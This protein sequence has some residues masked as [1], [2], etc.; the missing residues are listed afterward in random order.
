MGVAVGAHASDFLMVDERGADMEVSRTRRWRAFATCI[1][2]FLA[3][4]GLIAAVVHF[5][6]PFV[7]EIAG[8]AGASPFWWQVDQNIVLVGTADLIAAVLPVWLVCIVTR[9][10][11]ADLGYNRRGTWLAWLVVLTAQA[12]LLYLDTK[13]GA[14]GHARDALSPYALFASAFVGPAAAFSEET[15][16]RG[17]MTEELRRGGFGI[18][19][20]VT[21]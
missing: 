15:L 11:V 10:S 2:M 5:G 12:G 13:M 16:F 4:C 21:I 20:Q 1:V 7:K 14:L 19:G 3:Y 9:R 6:M 8:P 17:F 18:T